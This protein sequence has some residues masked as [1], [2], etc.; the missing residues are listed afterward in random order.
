MLAYRLAQFDARI[1]AEVS[2]IVE[3][4]PGI[5]ERHLN[6]QWASLLSSEALRSVECSGGPIILVIDALDECENETGRK[7]LMETLSKGFSD[8]P[9]FIRIIVVS[10]EEPDIQR[11]LGSHSTVYQYP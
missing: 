7:V 9:P 2:R 8:L 3:S 11:V 4:I 5:A 6:F 10:R 1:G